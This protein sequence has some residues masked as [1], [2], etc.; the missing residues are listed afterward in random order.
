MAHQ[1]RHLTDSVSHSVLE[2][3]KSASSIKNGVGGVHANANRKNVSTLSF[4]YAKISTPMN[5][6]TIRHS[7]KNMGVKNIESTGDID[8]DRRPM[9]RYYVK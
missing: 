4:Q 8:M 7:K 2:R 3:F 1:P 9:C 5:H 6:H